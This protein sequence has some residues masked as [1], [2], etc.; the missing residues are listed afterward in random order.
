MNVKGVHLL[1]LEDDK[2]DEL[3]AASTTPFKVV[4]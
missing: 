4:C 3:V 2:G 1:V